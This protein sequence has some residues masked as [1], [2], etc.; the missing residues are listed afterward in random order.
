MTADDLD[1]RSRNRAIIEAAYG[2]RSALMHSGQ[3]SFE[4]LQS[5]RPWRLAA[6]EVAA[7]AA[8]IA[9]QVIHRVLAE[10]QLPDW[11]R[12]ELS[13]RIKQYPE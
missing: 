3:S 6:A 1:K 12:P 4:G 5:A 11:E 9:A 2:L 7:E 10:G 8:R 13:S